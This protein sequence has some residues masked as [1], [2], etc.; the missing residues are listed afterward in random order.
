MLYLYQACLPYILICVQH[1]PT[2]NGVVYYKILEVVNEI[3]GLV[4]L[5]IIPCFSTV[6]KGRGI[7]SLS[8]LRP[9]WFSCIYKY[10]IF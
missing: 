4:R 7:Q 6:L 3:L 9:V 2:E 8:K 10:S 1:N 5:T